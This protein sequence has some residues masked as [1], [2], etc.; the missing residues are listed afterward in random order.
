MPTRARVRFLL[1][2][3]VVVAGG[4]CGHTDPFQ[5]PDE[6]NE[7]PFS[8]L[9]P[10]QLTYNPGPDLTPAFLPGD[11]L[12]LYSYL[13][14]QSPDP[15]QC[16]AALPVGGGTRVNES[17][18]RSAAALD[19]IERYESPVPLND[20][21]VVLV[22]SQRARGV[23]V[24]AVTLLGTAPWRTADQMTPRVEFPF[25]SLS[26]VYEISASYP[27]LLGGNELAYLAVVDLSACPGEEPFCGAPS[28]LRVGREVGQLNLETS[29][30]PTI[31]PGTDWVTSIGTGRTPGSVLLTRPFDTRVYERQPDGST[32]TLY[33]F[34]EL[35]AARDPSLVGNTLVAI[36][37]GDVQRWTS[38]DGDTL[39]VDGG[40]N[41]ALV[42]LTGGQRDVIAGLFSRP[43]L[44]ADGR[45]LIAVTGDDL[46]R[47]DIP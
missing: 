31:L 39:Q 40:G 8:P 37:G 6:S 15:N 19:S 34:A 23:D 30:E 13:R 18:P 42:N 27:S 25:T 11:T 24:D 12:V 20:S 7:G 46:Y 32:V 3:T 44:S 4:A 9:V 14:Y 26:G 2:L 17:C 29:A 38:N 21:I 47:F 41:I 36:V 10:I 28:L 16:L 22:S 43:V 35:G 5:D 1:L 45:T 33:D